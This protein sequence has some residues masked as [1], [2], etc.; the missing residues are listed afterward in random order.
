MPGDDRLGRIRP[1]QSVPVR[2]GE[3]PAAPMAI[4]AA[5]GAS[6][7]ARVT[8]TVLLTAGEVDEALARRTAYRAPGA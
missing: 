5:V 6:G 8:T 4:A 2:P 1:T 7:G 3:P